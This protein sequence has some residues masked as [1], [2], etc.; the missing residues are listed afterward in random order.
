MAKKSANFTKTLQNKV[1]LVVLAIA[2]VAGGAAAFTGKSLTQPTVVRAENSVAL[3]ANTAGTGTLAETEGD[4]DTTGTGDAADADTSEDAG[5]VQKGDIVD[6]SL[7]A[8]FS[9]GSGDLSGL[10]TFT[11][12]LPEHMELVTGSQTVNGATVDCTPSL[13]GVSG[14][15]WAMSE[16]TT[17]AGSAEAGDFTYD[18][19]TRTLKCYIKDMEGAG[20]AL[21]EASIKIYVK[22]TDDAYSLTPQVKLLY[23][24]NYATV[25]YAQ[26]T[27]VSNKVRFYSG[28]SDAGEYTIHYAWTGA[29][30]EGEENE[31]PKGV[32]VPEDTKYLKSEETPA[33]AVTIAPKMEHQGYKFEGWS[34]ST[35]SAIEGVTLTEAG[36]VWPN[37]VN[38]TEITLVGKWTKVT[39]TFKVENTWIGWDSATAAVSPNDRPQLTDITG[40]KATE[41]VVGSAVTIPQYPSTDAT[42]S[43]DA[44]AND[45]YASL[46]DAYTFLGFDIFAT[47]SDGTK[48][49][50]TPTAA[51]VENGQFVPAQTNGTAAL[52]KVTVQ[53]KWERKSFTMYFAKG[54]GWPN[55]V[56]LTDFPGIAGGQST[57]DGTNYMVTMKWGEKVVIPTA[58]EVEGAIFRS[59]FFEPE[60]QEL[61][62]AKTDASATYTMP[63]EDVVVRGDWDE[64]YTLTT[65]NATFGLAGEAAGKTTKQV[66]AG[67]FVTVTPS[68]VG[69]VKF[70]DYT[71]TDG[72][73]AD[74][75]TEWTQSADNTATF[76]MPEKN[77]TLTANMAL[78][79][80]LNIKNGK[81]PSGESSALECKVPVTKN[82]D[83]NTWSGTLS[84][85][86]V[87][88]TVGD[89]SAATPNESYDPDSRHWESETAGSTDFPAAYLAEGYFTADANGKFDTS[90]KR[91]FTFQFDLLTSI[92]VT[93]KV[94]AMS[95]GMGKVALKTTD[96]SDPVY[97]TEV[98]S[99]AFDPSSD[100]A[101]A[102]GT[103]IAKAEETYAFVRWAT[104]DYAIES[105][106][107]TTEF[108]P[109]KE[110]T[111]SGDTIYVARTYVAV[112]EKCAYQIKFNANGGTG[113]MENQTFI[114][115]EAGNLSANT[116]TRDGYVFAGWNTKADGSGDVYADEQQ[117]EKLSMTNGDVINLYA[118]WRHNGKT[119]VVDDVCVFA[120]D[121]TI[122][123]QEAQALLAKDEAGQLAEAIERSKAFAIQKDDAN[124]T[125]NKID[126]TQADLSSVKAMFGDYPATL[127]TNNGSTV[128]IVVHVVYAADDYIE[129]K[130][131][132]FRISIAEAE[133]L[134]NGE[135]LDADE[136]T[137][138][139]GT[140]NLNDAQ[141][142][143]VRLASAVAARKLCGD[144]CDI[145]K[146]TTTI[147]AKKAKD[148]SVTFEGDENAKTTINNVVVADNSSESAKLKTRMTSN[149]IE[150][151]FAEAGELLAKSNTA[152]ADELTEKCDAYA[153]FT[154]T[155]AETDVTET[156]WD[157]KQKEGT[158]TAT[159][160]TADEAK[161][162]STVKVGPEETTAAA[163]ATT[164]TG[165]GSAS[166]LAKTGDA[167]M[168]AAAILLLIALISVFAVKFSKE[169]AVAEGLTGEKELKKKKILDRNF[170]QILRSLSAQQ[171]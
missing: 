171:S 168:W 77:V 58:K 56:E 83:D 130:A 101:N 102:A 86:K 164:A 117:I 7:T 33:Q 145:K 127:S 57:D 136:I 148:F 61:T 38:G 156:E 37:T 159:F 32:E 78:V 71:C 155:G 82:L 122:T 138:L 169:R 142:E 73:P 118:Q 124:K 132:T 95:D 75:L 166:T 34:I 87:T 126:V 129:I 152:I 150:L 133:A 85:E 89:L 79:V 39:D 158:Y 40:D 67:S 76:V 46:Y 17:G 70:V 146:V 5:E 29:T 60:M 64:A 31:P 170:K 74:V 139:A 63:K 53:G 97:S 30:G 41:L 90:K 112:F 44:D 114:C 23:Y 59:W 54:D 68:E 161:V 43:D 92:T 13:S 52:T 107:D 151:T 115:D 80:T 143:M 84:S 66:I 108:S 1:I 22:V 96:G 4:G 144:V 135:V 88:T 157:I 10:V 11:D 160:Y 121:I 12:V 91:E 100:A 35:D 26:A 48:V 99:A 3:T 137:R 149:N 8:K 72:Q 51:E 20:D 62:A 154:D 18:A 98:T 104:E 24:T 28:Y 140:S 162:T 165:K 42:S 94:F 113:A 2:L 15:K 134:L 119:N 167:A 111:E 81:W 47:Y 125:T 45:T 21:S 16:A 25:N 65:V 93:Y 163:A 116:F 131:H 105:V 36:L 69:D 123:I 14:A 120:N 141:E 19:T 9:A 49:T 27:S 50:C 6:F 106:C 110:L 147:K 103:A 128:S 55:S 153:Y 109:A